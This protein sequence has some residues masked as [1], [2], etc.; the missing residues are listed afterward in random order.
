MTIRTNIV[1]RAMRML[2][3]I[4]IGAALDADEAAEAMTAFQDMLMSLPALGLGG[5]LDD[6]LISANYTAGENE[7]ITDS[8]GS[9]VITKPTTVVDDDTGLDRAPR[10]GAVIQINGASS[11]TIWVYVAYLQAW[12]Q[13]TGLTLNSE[14]PL[15]PVHNEGLAAML[16]VRIASPTT[17]ISNNVALMAE[18]GINDINARFPPDLESTL[19]R[20]FQ[21]R[22]QFRT[23]VV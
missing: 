5:P 15:G 16:A 10:N 11:P 23:G 13:F 22:R 21:T 20:S 9:A 4:G 7:A 14:S 18:K 17:Q 6:V 12:K 19:D 2:N 8:S 1:Q 3:T